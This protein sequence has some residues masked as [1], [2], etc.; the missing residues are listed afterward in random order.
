MP[1]G[2]DRERRRAI[3]VENLAESLTVERG[4]KTFVVTVS[5]R[6]QNPDKSA[7]IANTVGDVFVE[8][9]GQLQSDTAGKA[10]DELN[11]R[12]AEL[13]SGVEQAERAAEQF[14]AEHD[15]VDAQG[16]LISEDELVKLNDQLSTARARTIELNARAATARN[17][18]VDSVIG[19]GLPE[20]LSSPVMAELRAQYAAIKQQAD[21]L[22]VRLG[23]RHPQYLAMQ[24]QLDGAREQIANE[25]K[26]LVA[27]T[28]TDLKRAVQQEQDLAA[29]LAQLKVRSGD[30]NGD[31]ITLRELER[32]VTAKRAVYENFLVRAKEAGEQRDINTANISVISQAYPPLDPSGPSRAAISL[33]GAALG[34]MAGVGLGI[35]RGVLWGLRD[36]RR[37]RRRPRSQT[38][39]SVDAAQMAAAPAPEA[40]ALPTVEPTSDMEAAGDASNPLVR[41]VQRIRWPARSRSFEENKPAVAASAANA[42][43][44]SNPE[45]ETKAPA[46]SDR[47]SQEAPQMYPYPPQ[48]PAYPQ[49]PPTSGPSQPQPAY[50]QAYAP[51]QAYMPQPLPSYPPP[52]GFMQP[53]PYPY[54]AGYP[55]APPVQ[56][57]FHGWQPQ[58]VAAGPYG[59][60]QPAA[61]YPAYPQPPQQPVHY[62]QEVRQEAWPASQPAA[63]AR[64]AAA[65]QRDMTPLEEV[66]ESLR[67]FREAI[68]DLAEE[69]ARRKY[70]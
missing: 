25:L 6:T 32:E 15:L 20:E 48:S 63:E 65:A 2:I 70:S 54:G 61:P 19:G 34:F 62:P 37:I 17:V 58:P 57:A 36:R 38:A 46:G 1:V 39:P 29:R 16:R 45:P 44:V 50:P 18:K 51:A 47:A 53:H 3:A 42:D 59:Y 49:Q 52:P 5:A 14:R 35:G 56:P 21:Q 12:L 40:A 67:E 33:A 69:R 43:V 27:S 41:L 13:R 22:S 11:A 23:P 24:A 30:V 66:R 26:R 8:T 68:R 64:P 7:L 9:T 55:Y 4:G 10:A 31:M 60:P 28:Q